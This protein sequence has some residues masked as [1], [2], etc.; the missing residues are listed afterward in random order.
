MMSNNVGSIKTLF[1]FYCLSILMSCE[2]NGQKI[3]RRDAAHVLNLIDGSTDPLGPPAGRLVA[4]YKELN[5]AA[6]T[7]N[8]FK[9]Q[10]SQVDS[11]QEYY[12]TLIL[13]YDNAIKD[14]TR[15]RTLD[16]FGDLKSNFLSLLDKGREP[17]RVVIPVHIK[18][19]KLGRSVLNL[20]E[21]NI[22]STK[23]S[24]FKNSAMV[25]L[26]WAKIVAI[27]EDE[28]EKQYHLELYNGS[29]R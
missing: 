22:I 15:D 7:G 17:W 2:P 27:R 23:D 1:L 25:S 5:I 26:E 3:Q 12:D 9:L 6:N 29:Y 19:F 28:I 11:L 14:I 20:P 4:Y 18:M 21:Q 24:I 13:V 16:K 10:S 8:N